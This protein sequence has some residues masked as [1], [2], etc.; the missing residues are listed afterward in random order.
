MLEKRPDYQQYPTHSEPSFKYA[1]EAQKILN[2]REK[3]KG[4]DFRQ[5]RLSEAVV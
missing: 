4:E 1:A 3:R 5:S 2:S